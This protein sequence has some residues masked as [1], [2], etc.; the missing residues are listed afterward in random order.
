MSLWYARRSDNVAGLVTPTPFAGT[1]INALYP[2]TRLI[3]RDPA[4]AAKSSSTGD[5][6]IVWDFTAPQAVAAVWIPIHNAPAG[7][8]MRFEGHTSSAWS[9][10]T[11]SRNYTV[12]AYG[13]DL[14]RGVFINLTIDPGWSASG[15]RFW[16]LFVPN[17]G[18][19]TALGEVFLASQ[20]RTTRNLLIGIQRP[21]GRV[22]TMHERNDGGFFKYDR[23]SNTFMAL[24]RVN[25]GADEFAD[26]LA[27]HE[28]ARGSL[29]PFAV[30][31]N[32]EQPTPEGYVMQWLGEFNP[33][34]LDVPGPN[35]TGQRDSVDLTW[36]MVP[37]GRAL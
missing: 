12:P 34:N 17:V 26:Y 3:D 32:P 5:F 22:V 20:L 15:L 23:G 19:I 24:G 10:P 16:S 7:I 30:V 27:I 29:Y 28:D 14:P 25:V 6:R 9:T 13:G 33:T 11:V 8:V 1:T 35:L 37:R 2:L 4:T 31:L 21:R 18:L 36:Q